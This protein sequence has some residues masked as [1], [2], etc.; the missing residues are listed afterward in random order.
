MLFNLFGW[1]PARTRKWN[2]L[3]LALTG[4]S[5]FGLGIF[6]GLGYCP[7]T[8]WHFNVLRNLGETGLP[9]SYIEYL[10]LRFTGTVL[11]TAAVDTVVT[12]GYFVALVMSVTLNVMDYRKKRK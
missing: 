2:L 8:D 12:I 6:Y 10:V 3:T 7:L 4:G 11:H 1:I 9:S 5:W